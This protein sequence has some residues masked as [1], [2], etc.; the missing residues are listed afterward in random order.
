MKNLN[1][2]TTP[3]QNVKIPK[4]FTSWKELFNDG[5]GVF[6]IQTNSTKRN[7]GKEH[8]KFNTHNFKKKC[9]KM[10]LFG[11]LTNSST[12]FLGHEFE[13]LM[14]YI[15]TFVIQIGLQ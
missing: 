1:C 11:V 15:L 7:R 9:V 13:N 6:H 5:R 2:C 12:L 8:C 3:W 14:A 4:F 10:K